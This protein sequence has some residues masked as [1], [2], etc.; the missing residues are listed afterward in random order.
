LKLRGTCGS[1]SVLVFTAW[2]KAPARKLCARDLLL[3]AVHFAE[4]RE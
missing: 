4:K 2:L 1:R 3:Q